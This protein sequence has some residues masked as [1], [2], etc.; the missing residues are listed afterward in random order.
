MDL[1]ILPQLSYKRINSTQQN[2]N[3][4]SSP[5]NRYLSK[6]TMPK[7][8]SVSFGGGKNVPN[9]HT[10]TMKN[11]IPEKNISA[12]IPNV[13]PVRT[14]LDG[15]KTRTN[16]WKANLKEEDVKYIESLKPDVVNWFA[17]LSKKDQRTLMAKLPAVPEDINLDADEDD[18]DYYDGYVDMRR[19]TFFEYTKLDRL[20]L[21]M[22]F[23]EEKRN[24]FLDNIDD[25][26]KFN[27]IILN[28]DDDDFSELMSEILLN[29]MVNKHYVSQMKPDE[30]EF[31]LNSPEKREFIFE[32]LPHGQREN[33][34]KLPYGY[35]QTLYSKQDLE[36]FKLTKYSTDYLREVL[37]KD[38]PF[39]YRNF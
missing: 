24:A 22:S 21:F 7:S 2:N 25:N 4:V 14:E 27:N 19:S 36:I 9:V 8:D 23:S 32:R 37:Y 18:E 31:F 1:K 17:S 35:R 10:E 39:R 33:I 20:K 26:E 11:D 3:N 5:Y 30:V 28:Y 38:V 13:G 29:T 6:L 12:D 16:S 34:F 15:S